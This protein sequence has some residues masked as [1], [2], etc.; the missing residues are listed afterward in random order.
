M[1]V[2]NTGKHGRAKV[3]FVGIDI[4]TQRKYED[5]CSSAHNRMV[6]NVCRKEY[7]VI[8]NYKCIHLNKNV[9][10]QI[11]NL[12]IKLLDISDD[13]FSC[14]FDSDTNE[15]RNDIK[16][17]EGEL[18]KTKISEFCVNSFFLNNINFLKGNDLKEKFEK[19]IPIK[20]IVLKAMGEEHILGF[21]IDEK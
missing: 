8:L 18:G 11:F 9:I 21:K 16:L 13:G 15:T 4:F 1:N 12:P 10:D 3:H 7:T 19:E 20:V 6:P 2:F 14:L 17:P 5:N